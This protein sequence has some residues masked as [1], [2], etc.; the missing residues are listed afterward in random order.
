M[1]GERLAHY[2]SYFSVIFAVVLLPTAL[3]ALQFQ[4]SETLV[5]E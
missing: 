5:K 3:I 2:I 1:M 4:T